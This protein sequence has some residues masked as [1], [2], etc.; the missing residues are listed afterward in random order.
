MFL[1]NVKGLADVLVDLI[2]GIRKRGMATVLE[3]EVITMGKMI[4]DNLDAAFIIDKYIQY[5]HTGWEQINKRDREFFTSDQGSA[6]F[7]GLPGGVVN[8]FKA[9]NTLKDEKGNFALTDTDVSDLF[10]YFEA[11]TKIA[12]SYIHKGRVPRLELKEGRSIKVWGNPN[13]MKDVD[14]KKYIVMFKVE[15]DWGSA[16]PVEAAASKKAT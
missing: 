14:M 10:S 5:S 7:R 1:E 8:E 6:I 3:P 9:L 12:I 15:L 13:Y 2:S 16:P 11:F 4:V